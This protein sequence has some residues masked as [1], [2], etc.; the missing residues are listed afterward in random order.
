MFAFIAFLCYNYCE[1]NENGTIS[2]TAQSDL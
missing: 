2:G 1:V